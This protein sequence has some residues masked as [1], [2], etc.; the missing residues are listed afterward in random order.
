MT[1]PDMA[2]GIRLVQ[3][4]RAD[5]MMTDLAMVDQLAA[6]NPKTYERAYKILTGFNIGAAV[7]KGNADLLHAIRDG[8]EVMQADG[9][10]RDIFAKYKIDADMQIPVAVKTE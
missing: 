10:Q 7:K 6:E 3:S 9:K 8:L 2:S 5:I 4:G 1:Y